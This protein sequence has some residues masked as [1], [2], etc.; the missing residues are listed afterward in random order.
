MRFVPGGWCRPR[1]LSPWMLIDAPTH[2]RSHSVSPGSAQRPV[3][4]PPGCT[5][6]APHTSPT[7]PSLTGS[8]AGSGCPISLASVSLSWLL[9]T[10]VPSPSTDWLPLPHQSRPLEFSERDTRM[11]APGPIQPPTYV[12]SGLLAWLQARLSCCPQHPPSTRH[13]HLGIR[14]ERGFFFF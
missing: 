13:G 7:P 9:G 1:L 2:P 3:Q 11:Q 14:G 5:L 10:I 6:P 8:R 4:W 12:D